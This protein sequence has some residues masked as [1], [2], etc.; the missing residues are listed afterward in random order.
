MS[1]A[2]KL[3]RT[4]KG[5]SERTGWTRKGKY[6]PS[7][8]A[9]ARVAPKL[10]STTSTTHMVTGSQ[11]GSKAAPVPNRTFPF[12]LV[13]NERSNTS[14]SAVSSPSTLKRVDQGLTTCGKTYPDGNLANPSE[15]QRSL[16]RYSP[17]TQSR[18]LATH[19]RAVTP[20]R[21]IINFPTVFFG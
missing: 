9:R 4:T 8:V 15:P 1:T 5:S 14:S 20:V 12:P 7:Q 3:L 21:T 16:H 10:G 18:A 11:R 19:R 17:P 6:C 13:R 2:T